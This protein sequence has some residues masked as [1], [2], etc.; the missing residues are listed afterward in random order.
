[1]GKTLESCKTPQKSVCPPGS[2]GTTETTGSTSFIG[3]GFW[4]GLSQFVLWL[5]VLT[6]FI[7]ICIYAARPQWSLKSDGLTIDAGKVLLASLIIALI[8]VIVGWLLK[9]VFTSCFC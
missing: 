5:L 6:S 7:W 2:S 1:M 8:I 4:F 9:M 3:T